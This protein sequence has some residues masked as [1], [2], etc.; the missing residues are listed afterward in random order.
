MSEN[1]VRKNKSPTLTLSHTPPMRPKA[2]EQEARGGDLGALGST[3]K[4][5]V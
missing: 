4:S 3:R 5:S 1:H 2:T